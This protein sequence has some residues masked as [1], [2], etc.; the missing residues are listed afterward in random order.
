MGIVD[1]CRGC[2]MFTGGVNHA[3]AALHIEGVRLTEQHDEIDPILPL[4]G[5]C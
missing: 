1:G 4:R 3:T 5:T 2:A